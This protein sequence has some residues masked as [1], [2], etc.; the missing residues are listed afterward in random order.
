MSKTYRREDRKRLLK[1]AKTKK[2]Y[3]DFSSYPSD[4]EQEDNTEFLYPKP[5]NEYNYKKY[6]K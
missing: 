3:K 1:K 2:Q 6:Q 5:M 4:Y